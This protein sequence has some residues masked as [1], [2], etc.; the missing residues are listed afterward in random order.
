[1]FYLPHLKTAWSKK[2][3]YALAVLG[4]K[5]PENPS[6][7]KPHG[8]IP[9]GKKPAEEYTPCKKAPKNKHHLKLGKNQ[10]YDTFTLLQDDT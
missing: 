4:K 6:R 3:T 5:S 2:Q 1:M 9:H 10:P 7:K 8:K